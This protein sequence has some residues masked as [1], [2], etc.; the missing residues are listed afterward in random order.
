MFDCDLYTV[1]VKLITFEKQKGFKE[2]YFDFP[3]M[4]RECIIWQYMKV[5]KAFFDALSIYPDISDIKLSKLL[6][7]QN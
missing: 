1:H 7:M 3:M 6:E 4:V 2:S 5:E